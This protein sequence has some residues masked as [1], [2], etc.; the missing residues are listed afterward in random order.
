MACD[1]L[2]G[3][4]SYTLETSSD[5]TLLE[6]IISTAEHTVRNTPDSNTRVLRKMMNKIL[7]DKRKMGT[8]DHPVW[9]LYVHIYDWITE[10][11]I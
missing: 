2:I 6:S 7:L 9:C 10:F 3:Y 8:T 4:I 5:K 11:P 1:V